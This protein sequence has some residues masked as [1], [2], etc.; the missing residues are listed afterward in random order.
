MGTW[1]QQKCQ[2]NVVLEKCNMLRNMVVNMS[3]GEKSGASNQV[4]S[5][6]SNFKLSETKERR[7]QRLEN[8]Q[9]VKQAL[10]T[11]K[12]AADEATSRHA[13]G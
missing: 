13:F 6:N 11:A 5:V 3:K 4:Q 1:V 7:H 12:E 8:L 10:D 9:L 2:I